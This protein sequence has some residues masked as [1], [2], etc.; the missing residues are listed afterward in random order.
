[1]ITGNLS[2]IQGLPTS[3]RISRGNHTR[4]GSRDTEPGPHG[5]GR[6][7]N[8][9]GDIGN[10]YHLD[11]SR[12]DR[13]RPRFQS[14]PRERGRSVGAGRLARPD[15]NHRP[16]LDGVQCTACR[17]V[18]HVAKQCHMLA[19]VF[20]LERYMKKDLSPS[21]RD[22][23]EQEWLEKWK[24]WLDNPSSTPHQVLRTYIEA[25][26]ITVAGLNDEMDWSCWDCETDKESK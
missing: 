21:L 19:T 7:R 26:N 23:I 8:T 15:R 5:E 10:G 2:Q 13:G 18:G 9:G 20:F 22:A 17:R 12:G 3:N 1:M 16:F 14:S 6:F 4:G 11:G 25:L 24:E